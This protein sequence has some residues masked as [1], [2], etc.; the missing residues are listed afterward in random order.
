MKVHLELDG[1]R[2]LAASKS[3]SA[4][5]PT[6]ACL[7]PSAMLPATPSALSS[8]RSSSTGCTAYLHAY[9]LD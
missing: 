2:S 8:C 6:A 4:W 5:Q 1:L 9:S 3:S 7:L